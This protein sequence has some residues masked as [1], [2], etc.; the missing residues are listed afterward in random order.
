MKKKNPIKFSIRNKCLK[1]PKMPFFLPGKTG[2]YFTKIALFST[3]S[4]HCEQQW[5]K[6]YWQ[7]FECQ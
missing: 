6:G 5:W 4:A 1:L 2:S 7:I 3:V